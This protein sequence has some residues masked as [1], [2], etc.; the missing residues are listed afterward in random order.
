MRKLATI[1]QISEVAPI[2]G[3]DMIERARVD[4]WD[5]VIR[6]GELKPKD[7]CV[8]FEIDSFLPTTESFLFLE[9]NGRKK[10]IYEGKEVEGYRLRTCKLRGQIS[11]GLALPLSS[12]PNLSTT[13]L[14]ADVSEELGVIKYEAP[15]PA[16]LSGEV[17][18]AF[19]SWIS[20]SDE[21]R[22]QNILDILVTHKGKQFTVTEKVDGTSGTFYRYNGDFGVCG[23]NWELKESETNLYWRIA[24]KYDL[25]NKVPEGMAFQGEIIGEGVQKNK[26]KI[27]GQELRLFYV[28]LIPQAQYLSTGHMIEMGKIY[29]I[30]SVPLVATI[31][32]DHTVEQ[33]LEMANRKSLINPNAMAEGLV[34]R[35]NEPGPKISFKV[36]SNKYL[37][38][39]E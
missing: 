24:K 13:E 26:L 15:I 22:L 21:E 9:R 4:G 33:L 23:R 39:D 16:C 12:F 28:Y 20:K 30:E 14:G 25:V 27:K 35:L 31:T 17:K 11:Q 5:V 36:I 7:L 34:F 8:F 29:G 19:P 18:G 2:V 10:M 37:L 38:K 32:L 6:R 3:G 1:R